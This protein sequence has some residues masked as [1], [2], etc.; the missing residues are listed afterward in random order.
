MILTVKKL[1]EFV[2]DLPEVDEYGDD[3]EVWIG[4]KD[5]LSNCASS[6]MRLNK[7]DVIIEK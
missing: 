7:G 6:I 1:K 2:K 5:G 3:Y 4:E